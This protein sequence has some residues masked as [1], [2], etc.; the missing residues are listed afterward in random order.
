MSGC[1]LKAYLSVIYYLGVYLCL[2]MWIYWCRRVS[3]EEWPN[4]NELSA[5]C[6]SAVRLSAVCACN[7]HSGHNNKTRR[8]NTCQPATPAWR[9]VSKYACKLS[10]EI[11]LCTPVSTTT[12]LPLS[13]YLYTR[14]AIDSCAFDWYTFRFTCLHAAHFACLFEIKL[15]QK[16]WK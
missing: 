9:S 15:E 7:M 13:P 2:L 3:R 14:R 12:I 11:I 16:Y 8:N 10:T 4:N 6:V 1:V 5:F